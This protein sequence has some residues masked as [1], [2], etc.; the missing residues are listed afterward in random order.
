M[1]V[2]GLPILVIGAFGTIALATDVTAVR[3]LLLLTVAYV[4]V[5]MGFALIRA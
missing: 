3:L 4:A 2:V 5:N 1:V